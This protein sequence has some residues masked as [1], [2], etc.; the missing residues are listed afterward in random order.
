RLAAPPLLTTGLATL[1]SL[2]TFTLLFAAVFKIL[3]DTHVGWRDVWIGA[4][5]TALLFEAGKFG[6]GY[7]LGRES[8]ASAYGAA[9]SLVL[10]LLWIY[11][12]SLILF[13]GAA[14]TKVYARIHGTRAAPSPPPATPLQE[15]RVTPHPV[16]A[17]AQPLSLLILGTATG[18][19]AGLLLRHTRLPSTH[20]HSPHHRRRGSRHSRLHQS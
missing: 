19:V 16:A 9:A 5:F 7:Y 11:Y 12:A 15:T 13:F 8:T 14:F 1:L 6:L 17:A 18:L 10:V 2:T 20:A 4:A 3:P